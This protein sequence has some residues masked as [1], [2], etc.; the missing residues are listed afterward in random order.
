MWSKVGKFVAVAAVQGIIGW[1]AIQTLQA[2][3]EPGTVR[4]VVVGVIWIVVIGAGAYILV[5]WASESG[6]RR[7]RPDEVV[8]V[9]AREL[10]DPELPAASVEKIYTDYVQ[11]PDFSWDFIDEVGRL[12][13][14]AGTKGR[15]AEFTTTGFNAKASNLE[16]LSSDVRK[17]PFNKHSLTLRS[18]YTSEDGQLN[19]SVDYNV[20]PPP[21]FGGGSVGLNGVDESRVRGTKLLMQQLVDSWDAKQSASKN[22]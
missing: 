17:R 3:S 15:R 21:L 20:S 7:K 2:A 22:G 6:D 12:L 14:D 8:E 4:T 5:H 16:E 11:L 1:F 10:V 13:T 18:E 19:A 9:E